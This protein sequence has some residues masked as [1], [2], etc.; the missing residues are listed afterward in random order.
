M[1]LIPIPTRYLLS[2]NW[3]DPQDNRWPADALREHGCPEW[4]SASSA[5]LK[6]TIAI[7]PRSGPRVK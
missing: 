6:M 3:V 4:P 1:V 5:V 7:S 2:P